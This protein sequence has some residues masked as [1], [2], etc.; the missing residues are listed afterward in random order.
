MIMKTVVNEF[1]SRPETILNNNGIKKTSWVKLIVSLD[2][3]I[4]V[5]KLP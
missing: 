3:T 4:Q 1:D 5:Y 2:K